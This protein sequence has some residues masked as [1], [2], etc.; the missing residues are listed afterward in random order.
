MQKDDSADTDI[1]VNN[2]NNDEEFFNVWVLLDPKTL[3][4][5][6]PNKTYTYKY[7]IPTKNTVKKNCC[8]L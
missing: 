5:P 8:L 2:I 6:D 7:D 1:V 4:D 3:H